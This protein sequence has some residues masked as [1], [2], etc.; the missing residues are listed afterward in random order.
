MLNFK[1][2]PFHHDL[3]ALAV[4][5]RATPAGVCRRHATVVRADETCRLF[6]CPGRRSGPCASARCPSSDEVD[7]RPRPRPFGDGQACRFDMQRL[8]GL[9]HRR[10]CAAVLRRHGASLQRG[11]SRHCRFPTTACRLH[12]RRT[13]TPAQTPCRLIDVPLPVL[14]APRAPARLFHR[15]RGNHGISNSARRGNGGHCSMQ[16][17]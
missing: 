8:P 10:A 11:G 12:P 13:G 3:H 6:A 14:P 7:A 16:Q 5:G 1:N 15:F 9:L 17:K 4:T 2:A